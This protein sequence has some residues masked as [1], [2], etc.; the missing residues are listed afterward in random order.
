MAR[1]S[2]ADVKRVVIASLK[3]VASPPPN[4]EAASFV[5]LTDSQEHIYLTTLRSKLNA[6][7]YQMNDGSSNYLAYYDI[8]LT[9]DSIDDWQT[10]G[11]SID[12][13]T[14]SQIIIYNS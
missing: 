8:N 14:E 12:W 11:D 3:A 9:P 10:I 5:G 13:I 6:L 7:P 4:V 1:L 2:R